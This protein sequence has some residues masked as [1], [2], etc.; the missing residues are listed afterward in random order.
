MILSQKESYEVLIATLLFLVF[1]GYLRQ[2]FLNQKMNS[3]EIVI[4]TALFGAWYG[5]SKGLANITG[6]GNN[7]YLKKVKVTQDAS[8]NYQDL[9][10]VQWHLYN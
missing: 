4:L 1:G 2:L 3:K 5:L 8:K 10:K 7:Y 6:Y 9:E